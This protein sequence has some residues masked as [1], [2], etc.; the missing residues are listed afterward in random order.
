MKHIYLALAL[1]APAAYAADAPL[2]L[3]LA[4][5]F[6]GASFAPFWTNERVDRQSIYTLL[7]HYRY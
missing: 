3:P 4:D 6:A 5:S 2:A 1:M 7:S